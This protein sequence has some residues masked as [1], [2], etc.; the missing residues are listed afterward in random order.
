MYVCNA[1]ISKAPDHA[2]GRGRVYDM[3][4]GMSGARSD[5]RMLQEL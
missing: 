1:L 4:P 5:S 3:G 2:C